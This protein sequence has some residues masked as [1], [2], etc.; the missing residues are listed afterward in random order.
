MPKELMVD[1]PKCGG[2][3]E[4]DE[5]GRHYTCFFCCNRGLVPES[6]AANEARDRAWYAFVAAEKAI[7]ERIALGVPAGR[8]YYIDEYEGVVLLPEPVAKDPAAKPRS[9]ADITDADL[10][11]IP[12]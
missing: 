2:V 4:F 12:F 11:D 1:C 7:L 3:P 5:D 8:R 6:V 9:W 10:E